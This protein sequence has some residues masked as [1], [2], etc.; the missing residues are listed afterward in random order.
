MADAGFDVWMINCRGNRYSREN[1]RISPEDP[2]FWNFSW[3]EMGLYDL[4][5]IINH[6]MRQTHQQRMFHV[7]HSQGTT[8]L[9]ILLAELPRFNQNIIAHFSFSPVAFMSHTISPVMSLMGVSTAAL[10][11]RKFSNVQV[12]A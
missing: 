1:T 5:A 12:I 7:G 6:I 8:A 9:Y 3:Q 11:V 10:R 4:P 2:N